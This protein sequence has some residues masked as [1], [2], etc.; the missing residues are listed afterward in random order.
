MNT[1]Q[2]EHVLKHD[3]YTS[4]IL[5]GVYA[6][7]TLPD[8]KTGCYIVNTDRA[9]NPGQHWLAL[10]ITSD[11]IEY[12]DSYGGQPLPFIKNKGKDRSWIY[13]PLMLQSPLT[14]VCG[15]YCLYY[16][17]HR[18]RGISLQVIL[19]EFSSDVDW[20]N[21][22][23]YDFIRNRYDFINVNIIDTKA[24]IQQLCFPRIRNELSGH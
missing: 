9:C 15:Q 19:N 8:L 22:F 2:L 5:R 13:N 10:F 14:S 6:I 16:L 4:P 1:L 24:V 12:F 11:E 3:S 23:V 17:L 21:Q 7:D 20:N 18:A